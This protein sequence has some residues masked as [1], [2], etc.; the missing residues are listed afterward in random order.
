[1]HHFFSCFLDSSRTKTFLKSILATALISGSVVLHAQPTP[2]PTGGDLACSTNPNGNDTVASAIEPAG[3]F[4]LFDGASFKGWWQSCQ[5]GHSGPAIFRVDAGQK[6]IYSTQKGTTGGV[7]MTNKKFGNYE[8]IFDMWPDFNND[9]GL[10]NR[11]PAN[12]NCFQTVLDYIGAGSVGGTWGENGF[13]G[14]DFRPWSYSNENTITI[15]PDAKFGW[16]NFTKADPNRNAYGCPNGCLAADYFRLWDVEG[17]NQMRVKFYGGLTPGAGARVH[18]FSFFR[19]SGS[20][21]WVPI[22]A[23]TTVLQDNPALASIPANYIGLQV[24]AGGRFSGPKGT[25]YRSIKWR[26]LDDAGKPMDST[27]GVSVLPGT[28]VNYDIQATHEALTGYLDSDHEIIVKNLKGKVLEKFSGKAGKFNYVFKT[29][30]NGWLS[31]QVKTSQGVQYRQ[32]MR[33]SH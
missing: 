21:V 18:M 13:P 11:T 15:S 7:L 16:T 30:E 22:S 23:D 5:T 32:V 14:R 12:G 19:K 31:L 20:D 25:W 33:D 17:W 9:G 27:G 24:H 29:R 2:A 8:I 1:M 4:N 28:K 3:W 26:R 10:F 6:A